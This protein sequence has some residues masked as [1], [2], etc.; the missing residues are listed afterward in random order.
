MSIIVKFVP[1]LVAVSLGCVAQY[2]DPNGSPEGTASAQA[3]DVTRS[4]PPSTQQEQRQ[5]GSIR[6]QLGVPVKVEDNGSLG[7]PT[8]GGGGDP[9]QDPGDNNEPTPQPWDPHAT[10]STTAPKPLR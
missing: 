4:A 8:P 2:G 1:L 9:Q 7:S 6:E 10:S 5:T 3:V